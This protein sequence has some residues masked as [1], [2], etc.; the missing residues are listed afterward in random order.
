MGEPGPYRVRA[1]DP[2]SEL[3]LNPTRAASTRRWRGPTRSPSTR[4]SRGTSRIRPGR[5]ATAT[6]PCAT[7]HFLRPGRLS[8]RAEPTVGIYGIEGSK[9]GAAAAAVYLAHR[10]IRPDKSGYGQIIGQ[11]LFSCRRLYARLLGMAD[12]DD[13]FVVVP[14]PRLPAERAGRA[15]GEVEAQRAVRS[16]ER[17]DRASNEEIRGRP[18]GPG[19]AEGDR[20]GPEHPWLRLQPQG[21]RGQ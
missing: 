5:C 20:S 14:V 2:P 6:R 1:A 19:A 21:T 4:T 12:P 15:V 3:T 10:V 7:C 16:A 9:P 13:P 8:W 17:I 11:A 18:R